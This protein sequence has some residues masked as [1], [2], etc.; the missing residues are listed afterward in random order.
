MIKLYL[1]IEIISTPEN[2]QN[3]EKFAELT[4]QTSAETTGL[5]SGNE[6]LKLSL[7]FHLKS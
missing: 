2:I 6:K 1:I 3:H 5:K 7:H 4:V